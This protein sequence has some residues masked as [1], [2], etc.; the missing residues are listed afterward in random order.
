MLRCSDARGPMRHGR[1]CLDRL[2][3]LWPHSSYEK[4]LMRGAF[5]RGSFPGEIWQSY[6]EDFS[7]GKSA[8]KISGTTPVYP[9]RR[10]CRYGFCG[11]RRVEG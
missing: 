6:P 9:K 11:I 2:F 1:I 4:D 5:A 8:K 7:R 10:R 3:S